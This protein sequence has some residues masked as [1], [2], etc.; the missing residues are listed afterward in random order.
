MTKRETLAKMR[1]I[2]A[3][4]AQRPARERIAGMIARGAI[5]SQGRVLIRGP[6]NVPTPEHKEHPM[7]P[8]KQARLEAAGYKFTTVDEW[9]GLTDEDRRAINAEPNDFTAKERR[10]YEMRIAG[11]SLKAIGKAVGMRPG[12]VAQALRRMLRGMVRRARPSGPA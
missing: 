3:R 5:D 1:E 11:E 7:D 9:L 6:E 10:I 4:D 12:K 8:E 2:L